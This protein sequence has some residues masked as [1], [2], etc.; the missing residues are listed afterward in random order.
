MAKI[1]VNSTSNRM[2]TQAGSPGTPVRNL[3]PGMKAATRSNGLPPRPPWRL[4]QTQPGSSNHGISACSSGLKGDGEHRKARDVREGQLRPDQYCLPCGS[5]TGNSVLVR[6][7]L[8]D[9]PTSVRIRG[10]EEET[11]RFK[12]HGGA[13]QSG[14]RPYALATL[15][16]PQP[17]PSQKC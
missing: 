12:L 9:D 4:S 15:Q 14:L 3:C 7:G 5:H 8:G 11:G 16:N 10:L 13:G 2:W 17:E 1:W 6:A